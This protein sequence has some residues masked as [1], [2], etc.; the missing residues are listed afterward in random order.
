[1]PSVPNETSFVRAREF[2][3]NFPFFLVAVRGLV[4]FY[5]SSNER[6][7]IATLK[8]GPNKPIKL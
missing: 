6:T 2:E 1:M 5:C 8:I 3:F 7:N 4:H